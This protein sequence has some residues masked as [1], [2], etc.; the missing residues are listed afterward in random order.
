MP[1]FIHVANDLGDAAIIGGV[2][3]RKVGPSTLPVDT[4]PGPGDLTLIGEQDFSLADANGKKYYSPEEHALSYAYMG[5]DVLCPDEQTTTVYTATVK[6]TA[7]LWFTAPFSKYLVY[8]DGVQQAY[9]PGN[10]DVS[11]SEG[12]APGYILDVGSELQVYKS[13]GARTARVSFLPD[14]YPE[15]P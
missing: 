7:R 2:P 15:V 13:Q 9:P 11:S 12:G 5:P 6:G 10:T 14:V 1:T 3:F 8:V 4:T